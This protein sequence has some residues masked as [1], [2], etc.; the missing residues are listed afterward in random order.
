M[1]CASCCINA[2]LENCWLQQHQSALCNK[3]THTQTAWQQLLLS[4]ALQ[5]TYEI[6]LA[7]SNTTTAGVAR[8]HKKTHHVLSRS[9]CHKFRCSNQAHPLPSTQQQCYMQ[10]ACYTT[11]WTHCSRK[12]T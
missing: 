5:Q 12:C 3:C 1:V 10:Q 2:G 6:I 9:P 11:S 8:A 4:P 7:L